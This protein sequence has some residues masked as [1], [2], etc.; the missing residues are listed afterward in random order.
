M[1]SIYASLFLN[2]FL[3]SIS[4]NGQNK[5]C[6]LNEKKLI[7]INAHIYIQYPSQK[8]NK[9]KECRFL[10]HGIQMTSASFQKRLSLG[11]LSL[12]YD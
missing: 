9:L 1:P 10:F 12:F 6:L 5:L 11:I 4:G 3:N 7:R 2:I 8:V